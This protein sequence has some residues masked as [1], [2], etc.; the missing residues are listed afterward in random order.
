M[1]AAATAKAG[2]DI[3]RI[4]G[5]TLALRRQG[6]L[7]VG[8]CPFHAEGSPSFTVFPDHF[9]CYGCGEH[10]DVIDWLTD[11]RGMTFRDA[12]AYLGAPPS[13][14]R[15]Q[16]V[17]PRI[18][19]SKAKDHAALARRIWHEAMDDPSHSIVADYLASRGLA[20]PPEP[21]I[22][23][24]GECP[25]GDLRLPAMIALLSDPVTGEAT[26]GVHRTFL[27]PDGSGKADIDRPK[28]MLGPWGVIRLYEPKTYGVGFAEGVE[29][30]LAIVLRIGW[31]P[32]W[33]V[34]T[35]GGFAKVPPLP[36]RT[37]NYFV[38]RDDDGVSLRYAEEG[39]EAWVSAGL[40]AYIHEP[41][42]GTD[43]CDCT[44]GVVP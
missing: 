20:L 25:C 36:A 11:Q 2:T 32:V 29:T 42:D 31:G 7:H 17:A 15:A 27:R 21:V 6:R 4:I 23:F 5:E 16:P 18:R 38:D 13:D 34:C 1:S 26:G 39:A 10:G 9:H 24:H 14:M 33:A 44:E 40:E 35:A 37:A 43:W 8:L 22:R 3:V 30:A 12:L 28:M 41:P 19:P